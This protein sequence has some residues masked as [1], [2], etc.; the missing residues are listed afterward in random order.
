LLQRGPVDQTFYVD[1][2][3]PTNHSSCQKTRLIDLSYGIKIWTDLK[4]FRFV[5]IHT[6]DRQ[7]DRQTDGQ[8]EFSSLDRVCIGC[9]AV[10]KRSVLCVL[11]AC[12]IVNYEINEKNTGCSK[13]RSLRL[14]RNLSR[15]P[16]EKN[17]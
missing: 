9:S 7:T 14:A 2:I 6:F 15:S 1:V 3:A 11:V 8:T 10:I 16:Q 17:L 5:T 4:L 12:F 13:C